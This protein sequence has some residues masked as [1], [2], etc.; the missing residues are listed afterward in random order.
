MRKQIVN[1]FGRLSHP[2]YE[3]YMLS[4]LD[5]QLNNELVRE[6]NS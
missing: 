2:N 4:K 3:T 5:F 1:R 6:Y